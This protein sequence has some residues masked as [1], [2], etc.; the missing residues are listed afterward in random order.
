MKTTFLFIMGIKISYTINDIISSIKILNLRKNEIFQNTWLIL[1]IWTFFDSERFGLESRNLSNSCN[2]L[3]KI[4]RPNFN[5]S[6]FISSITVQFSE[7]ARKMAT[8]EG[9]SH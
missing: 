2:L 7:I 4:N 5:N 1:V 3:I 6:R 9:F 8:E